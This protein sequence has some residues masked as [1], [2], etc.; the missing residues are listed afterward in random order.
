MK[1]LL[2]LLWAPSLTL[3]GSW[4]LPAFSD[5]QE[6]TPAGVQLSI[7][8]TFQ[9]LEAQWVIPPNPSEPVTDIA[10]CF[11]VD[12]GGSP[13]LGFSSRFLSCP[14][15]QIAFGVSGVFRDL[16]FT[17]D[18]GIYLATP[19][20]IGYITKKTK[21]F[22]TTKD[23]FP[24]LELKPLLGFNLNGVRLFDGNRTG[25]YLAGENPAS[26]K[27]EIY[28]ILPDPRHPKIFKVL[29][30][31]FMPDAIAG[32]GKLTFLASGSALFLVQNATL[33][34]LPAGLTENIR[35]LAFLDKYG[36]FYATDSGVGFIYQKKY[37]VNL[38]KAK[39]C[40]IRIRGSDLFI[41]IPGYSAVMTLGSLSVFSKS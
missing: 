29:V 13:W 41:F 35:D 2:F 37:A 34:A 33:T 40:K 12:K 27:C 21:V 9:G 4:A 20:G 18:G 16:C 28:Y 26:K 7:P 32:D 30:A 11:G 5:A 19:H 31:D 24:F 25:F 14:T 36:L 39:D 6:E 23:I 10:D 3:F 15:K 38:L 1:K 22:K 8:Q 17:S